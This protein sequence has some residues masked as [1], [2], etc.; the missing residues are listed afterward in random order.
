MNNTVI[1]NFSDIELTPAM[2][3]LLNRGLNFSI[4]PLKLDITEVLVDFKSFERRTLW[5]E[6][7]HNKD[8][9]ETHKEQIFK[10]KKTN[11]P[12][13]HPTPQGLKTFLGSVKSEILDPRN[14]N[15]E[16][17]N[18]PSDEI[19]AL[20]EL[21]S[22][23]RERKIVIKAADKGSGIVISDFNK[24]LKSAYEHLL[25][26]QEGSGKH[27]YKEVQAIEIDKAKNRIKAVLNDAK[28]RGII[29]KEEYYHMDPTDKDI[30]KFYLNFKV[31]KE[32]KEG[33][34]PPPRPIIS[35]RNSMTE[36]IAQFVEHYI[37]E[38]S[39][40]HKTYIQDTPDFLRE[41]EK[42][43][44]LDNNS[45]LA[46]IDV[47]ALFTN[48]PAK[49]GLESLNTTL[50][51]RTNQEIPT[52]FL[53]E[54]MKLTLENNLFTF[55]DGTFR[56]EIGSAM[57]SRSASSYANTYMAK[58]VDPKI[59][60]VATQNA[61]E[62]KFLKRFLDDLFLIFKGTSKELHHFFEQIN[63]IN[64][65]IKF[66]MTH[67]AN[68]TET[69][70]QKC[71]CE[72][73]EAI[74]FL[75]TLCSIKNK[76]IEVDL[77]KKETDKNQ[78]LL[79]NS[80]HPASVTK[81][82]PFSLSLRIVRICTSY[83]NR[84]KRLSELKVLLKDRGYTDFK[85]DPAIAKA[86]KIPR[87]QALKKVNKDAISERPIF[88][89]KFDPRWPSFT[90]IMAKHWRS[91]ICQDQHLK[92]V[93]ESP[94]LIAYKRQRNIKD[95]LIR[96]KVANPP[97]E[98]PLRENC[99]MKKC[100]KECTACPYIQEGKFVKINGQTQWKIN[101]RVNC[102]SKNLIYMIE[103]SECKLRYIG[104]TKRTLKERLSDHRGYVFKEKTDQA[105]GLHFNQ[106]G[107]NLSN[108]KITVLEKVKTEEDS[109]R[110]ERE[111]YFINKFNTFY[112][113]LN[114]QV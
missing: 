26:K 25:S 63:R 106:P 71:D 41:V 103:C 11:L 5:K 107:H 40:R 8:S 114:R 3:S 66:T 46:S 94:P 2:I 19:Q 47:K 23:Q 50:N 48:I 15:R 55:H 91:M 61:G 97:K 34:L 92:E 112:G 111:K 22:L 4:L 68:N 10:S 20:K 75:D 100:G 72:P 86:L 102:E 42:V 67:T 60:E 32:H 65:S 93:F 89:V 78:Y 51:E 80:C 13:N 95:N 105:T 53:V 113:G 90:N 83:E 76:N 77:Y 30:A 79:L 70:D 9:E 27:Y 12:K 62:L 29:T 16:E 82:I 52:E 14:R 64:P 88:A 58:Q 31:H 96:A 74:P 56:Q 108:I 104:E 45:I 109:Y 37:K 35:G 21:I 57:G 1:F 69:A 84:K 85:I 49:E 28:E 43:T 17:C 18:I 101:K 59:E 24:Y 33:E 7:F 6:F 98:R 110:K 87:T 38:L 54:L 44:D 39:T 99:G 81:S 73:I 36:G